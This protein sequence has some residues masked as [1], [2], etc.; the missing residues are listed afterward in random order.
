MWEWIVWL[1]PPVLQKVPGVGLVTLPLYPSLLFFFPTYPPPSWMQLPSN[2][3]QH[4][5]NEPV[6][7]RTAATG[8]Y[9]L[10]WENTGEDP[11][12]P[13]VFPKHASQIGPPTPPRV[14]RRIRPLRREA[15][16]RR[17]ARPGSVTGRSFRMRLPPRAVSQNRKRGRDG[18]SALHPRLRPNEQR[19]GSTPPVVR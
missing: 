8:V 6:N 11:M 3:G 5:Q 15:A 18:K 12:W 10:L 9:A 17:S 1:V 2:V 16:C 7:M 13:L 14:P 19:K 4:L